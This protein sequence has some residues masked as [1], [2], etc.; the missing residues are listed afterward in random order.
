[1]KKKK[2]RLSSAE[3]EKIENLH[4]THTPEAIAEK[5]NR[6]PESIAKHIK[7][8][9]G[10]GATREEQAAF[11]LD[12]RPYW[13]E[14]R[15]QFTEEELKLF[16]YHWSRIISQFRDDVIP[17][18]ELQVV[19]LIK[20]ELLMNRALKGNKDNIEQI[21]ALD[22]LITAERQR[23]PD[24]IDTDQLFNM[25]RQVASLKASQESLNKDYRELQTKKNSMLKE[26]KATRE[27]RV[28]RL[29]DSKQNFTSWMAHLVANP[30]VTKQYGMEMEKMRLAM[31]K[32]KQRLSQFHK[33]TD[34]MVDQPFLTPDTV[35]D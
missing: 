4:L 26:M 27:Q 10:M 21:S 9:Y 14:L 7:K 5:L 17:T 35:K 6:D 18:E 24:Q 19:D 11:E 8:H 32:E 33:Y 31:D 28:K 3:I 25:E 13:A 12:S 22:A 20:L 1:M 15:Q 16:K 23:D 34:E 30:E 2:G 29:E